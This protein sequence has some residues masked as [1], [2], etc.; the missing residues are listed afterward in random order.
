VLERDIQAPLIGAPD[1]LEGIQ[2]FREKRPGN[3]KR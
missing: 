2:A 1:H 3:F